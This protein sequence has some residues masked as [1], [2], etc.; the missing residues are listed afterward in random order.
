MVKLILFYRERDEY[1]YYSN[2][3]RRSITIKNQTFHCNEQYIMYNKAML[4]G[5]TS[6][7]NT[8]L[9]TYEQAS[10]KA[11]GRQVKGFDENVWVANR[12]RIADECNMAKFSQHTD[13]KQYLLETGDAII[14]EAAK[15]DCIWGIGCDS[16]VGRDQSQW[17]GLN[18][19]GQ[20][21]MRIRTQLQ[22]TT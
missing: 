15:Y 12:E 13:L 20:S 21:L 4:F 1:G 19:L 6:T 17:R 10:I 22:T 2:F 5:D 11:L 3:Y 8:I 18:I 7:A 14:A 16:I 9:N